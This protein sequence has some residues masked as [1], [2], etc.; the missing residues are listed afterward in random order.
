MANRTPG[1]LRWLVYLEEKMRSWTFAIVLAWIGLVVAVKPAPASFHEW[2]ISEVYSN[3]SGSVQFIEFVQPSFMIDDERFLS[4]LPLA[5]SSSNFTF[6]GNLPSA[7]PANSHFLVATP[8]YAA[9]SGV[10]APDYTLAT[11]NFFSPSAGDT[12]TY[13]F[14]TDSL[15]FTSSQLPTNGSLSLN[16]ASYGSATLVS[17]PNSPTNFAGVTGTVPEPGTLSLLT[18]GALGFCRRRRRR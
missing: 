6:P 4:G 13:A 3:A 9:L 18:A 8:G 1:A 12:L 11:N 15:S 17:L 16:R 14:G 2:R 5:S 10:P 7:P